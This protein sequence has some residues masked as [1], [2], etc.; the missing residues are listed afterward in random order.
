M[1][2]PE[3]Q[4]TGQNFVDE[5]ERIALVC[6]A[7]AKDPPPQDLDWFR[8]GNRLQVGVENNLHLYLYFSI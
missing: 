6:N 5:G 1:F 7:T 8:E 3:I 2:K 4:I